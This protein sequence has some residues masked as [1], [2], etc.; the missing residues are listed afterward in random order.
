MI[1]V[2]RRLLVHGNHVGT[3][4]GEGFNVAVGLGDHQVAVQR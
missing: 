4:L 2:R 3:R 1:Q